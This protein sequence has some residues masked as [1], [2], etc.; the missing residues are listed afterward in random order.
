MRSHVDWTAHTRLQHLRTK[1][2]HVLGKPKVTYLVDSLVDEDVG[3]LKV[4]M[5]YLLADEFGESPEDLLHDFENFVF[6]E[7][8]A[9]HEFLEVSVFA[10]L[11]DD[12][13]AVFGAEDILEAY[14]VG[15]IEAFEKVDL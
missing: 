15:V 5:H 4:T 10:E 8:F 6:L 9:F 13:E 2:I 1:V 12:I 11:G 7:L 14:D 3:W